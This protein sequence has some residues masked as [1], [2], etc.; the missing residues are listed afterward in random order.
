MAKQVK[1]VLRHVSAQ[2]RAFCGRTFTCVYPGVARFGIRSRHLM[3][4]FSYSL[5]ASPCGMLM[6]GRYRPGMLVQRSRNHGDLLHPFPPP[7]HTG[8]DV[9]PAPTGDAPPEG[10]D[11]AAMPCR[12]LVGDLIWAKVV[13]HPWWPCM[14]SADPVLGR[15]TEVKGRAPRGF[16]RYHVQFFGD[17]PQ[18]GWVTDGGCVEFAGLMRF[19]NYVRE[20][21]EAARTGSAKRL[22]RR[23]YEVKPSHAW[24]VAVK[25][26]EEASAQTRAERRQRYT[27]VY[28]DLAATPQVAPPAAAKKRKQASGE[29]PVKKRAKKAA[30]PP[31]AVAGGQAVS[32][33]VG[34]GQEV[35]KKVGGG[36]AVSQKVGVGQ[37]VSQKFGGG[38]EVSQK[39]GGG[40]AVSEKVDGSQV[41]S[42][43]VAGGQEV[44]QKVGRGQ[45]VSKDV[46]RGQEVSKD[47]DGGGDERSAEPPSSGLADGEAL[48]PG[49]AGAESA[50]DVPAP[51]N[52]DRNSEVSSEE[53]GNLMIVT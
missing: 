18:R 34:G 14:V 51:V 33:K 44:S 32:Q 8:E 13:G 52:G 48:P 11:D 29:M 38:Q 26:A 24:D 31:P 16:R 27:F 19:N 12:W 7:T 43:K 25:V 2:H 1:S 9:A 47:V 20:R 36:Q 39:V 49:G 53:E 42:Q 50:P 21:V 28:A 35:S 4:T 40:Q 15:Y 37:V 3:R 22:V 46:G 10:A 23:R 45:K 41:V 30:A 5:F 17:A 6:I